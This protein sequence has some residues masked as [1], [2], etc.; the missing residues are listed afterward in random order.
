LQYKR[1][2]ERSLSHP[3]QFWAEMAEDFYWSKKWIPNHISWNFDLSKGP[4]HVEWFQGAE[5]NLCYNCLDR[6]V[7]CGRGGAT[8]FLW[9]GNEPRARPPRRPRAS[10]PSGLQTRAARVQATA[11]R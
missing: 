10:K 8:C 7:K 3:E 2:Y 6:N 4:V 5:T 1:L 9:E 11:R